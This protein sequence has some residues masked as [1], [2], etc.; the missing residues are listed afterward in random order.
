MRTWFTETSRATHTQ[1]AVFTLYPLPLYSSIPTSNSQPGR[2]RVKINKSAAPGMQVALHCS[3]GTL[4]CYNRSAIEIIIDTVD[5]A[6][7]IE[8]PQCQYKQNITTLAHG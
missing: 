8:E 3:T 1:T 7:V 4:L 5:I 2:S 6:N